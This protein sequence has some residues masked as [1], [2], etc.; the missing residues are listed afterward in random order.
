M[1][2]EKAHP[3]PLVPGVGRNSPAK[4]CSMPGVTNRSVAGAAARWPPLYE[5]GSTAAVDQHGRSGAGVCQGAYRPACHQFEFGHVRRHQF[6]QGRQITEHGSD[7]IPLEQRIPGARG[8]YRVQDIVG[9]APVPEL[10]GDRV[11]PL[12]V[13]EHAA[14]YGGN[15]K[16]FKDRR[17]LSG[18][19][20]RG[21]GHGGVYR[22]GVLGGDRRDYRQPVGTVGRDG[23]EVC[24]DAGP[25]AAVG[26][27][28]RED[29]F[30]A[31]G[32][33]IR[34]GTICL[35][36]NR[37]LTSDAVGPRGYSRVRQRS[38]KRSFRRCSGAS[39]RCTRSGR[40]V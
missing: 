5:Y 14:F 25:A 35:Y 18:D 13:D 33:R 1:A 23:L 2:D 8:D 7:C 4:A 29:R 20:V 37:P 10:F 31:I 19:E 32:A 16:G 36:P 11:D 21:N 26:S 39:W 28:D 38:A 9:R 27:G 3:V 30:H 34:I 12:A 22:P 6:R 15:V 24:L 17:E 40:A